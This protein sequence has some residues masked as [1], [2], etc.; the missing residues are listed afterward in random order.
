MKKTIA[1]VFAA[2]TLFLAGCCTPHH[3]TAREY[4][5]TEDINTVNQ[6][7]SQGWKVVGFTRDETRQSSFKTFL[8]ERDKQ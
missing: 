3:T 5:T 8:L 4:Q 6:L 7:A 2:S 1:L